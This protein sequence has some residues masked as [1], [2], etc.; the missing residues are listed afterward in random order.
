MA[1]GSAPA[2][3]TG[4][5]PGPRRPG[6]QP[7]PRARRSLI[8]ST[9][10]MPLSTQPHQSLRTRKPAQHSALILR[11]CCRY[12]TAAPPVLFIMK[13]VFT[14]ALVLGAFT[15][16]A[17]KGSLYIGGQAGFNTSTTEIDNN[18]LN[19]TTA[20]ANNYRLPRPRPI[21]TASRPKSAPSSPTRCSWA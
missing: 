8:S 11:G 19:T 2:P 3:T 10:K 6:G 7:P 1:R 21:T 5:P 14:A 17:Q 20:K 4:G 9:G 12:P 18:G 16:Q 15:A 13:H